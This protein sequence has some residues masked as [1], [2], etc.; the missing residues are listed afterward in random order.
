MIREYAHA[1]VGRCM[2]Q[3]PTAIRFNEAQFES[4]V[5]VIYVVLGT[6]LTFGVY[7]T[8]Q[9]WRQILAH[10]LVIYE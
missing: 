2:V 10:K 5:L 4:D 6:S 3:Q 9:I 7:V 8:G 1:F